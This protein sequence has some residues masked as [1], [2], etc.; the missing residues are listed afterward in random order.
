MNSNKDLYSILGVNKD[1][2]DKD[3]KSAYRKLAKTWHP[4]KFGDK[5]NKEKREAEEKF[6]KITEA[7]SILSD[8]DKRRQYDTFGTI[9]NLSG[10][11]SWSSTSAED[12]MK[13]FMR[14]SGFGSFRG[15]GGSNANTVKRGSDKKIRISVTIEDVFFNGQKDV[16]YEVERSCDECGGNGSKSGIS[17]KCPY[18]DGTGMITKTERNN[19]GFTQFSSPCPHCHGTGYYIQDPCG[20]CHGT[21]VVIEK[22]TQSFPIPKIDKLNLTY[23]MYGE[24]NACHNNMGSNGDL[25]YV[26]ALREEPNSKFYVDRSNYANICTDIDVSVIDCLTGCEKI[27]E[28]VDKK[29]LKIKIPKGTTD[30]YI[31]AFS[32]YGFRCSNGAVGKLLVKI[33]MTM[34]KLSDNQLNKIKEI[35]NNK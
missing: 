30:G 17:T 15:F 3:L 27:I 6:K 29:K 16:T 11:G 28:T 8:K 20:H 12:I 22:V 19:F 33:K 13:E 25:Y 9:D 23:K 18:C 4:D 10:S 35:V 34:P 24:G 7:Y 5:S 14:N 26:F 21:G 31:M 2:S 32:G 1:A